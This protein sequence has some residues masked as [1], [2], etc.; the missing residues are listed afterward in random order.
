MPRIVLYAAMRQLS[1]TGI[2]PALCAVTVHAWVGD[3]L[4]AANATDSPPLLAAI[5]G[6]DSAAVRSYGLFAA[7]PLYLPLLI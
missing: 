3:R 7:L 6:H 2:L 5:S 1:F 4:Q